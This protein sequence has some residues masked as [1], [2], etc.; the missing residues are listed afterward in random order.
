MANFI[1]DK[2][3]S[4]KVREDISDA[5]LKKLDGMKHEI[6]NRQPI[7]QKR[8]DFYEGRHDKWT[9]VT[10][11]PSKKQEGHILATFNYILKFCQKIVSVLVNQ[12]PKIKIVPKDESNEIETSRS[13]AL[14]S[15][16]RQVFKDNKFFP[17]KMEKAAVSQVRDGD[18]VI[19]CRVIKN[20]DT[21]QPEIKITPN[22]DVLK[23]SVGWD[24]A[25]GTSFSSIT[26][27]D[28][29]TLDKIKREYDF[30]AEPVGDEKTANA[31][32]RGSHNNDQ[33]GIFSNASGSDAETVPDGIAKVPKARVTDYWGWEVID[34]KAKVINIIYINK[35][36]KQFVV[37]D[38]KDIPKKVGHSFVV[39]GK[40]WSM[41]FIDPLIDPQ[42]ELNDRTGEEGDLV[43]VGSH[44]KFLVL[45]MPDFDAKSVKPGSGQVIFLE[46]ENVDFKPLQM[47]ISPF[48]SDVYLDRVMEHMFNLGLPKIALSAGTAPYT[49]RVA[50]I[51]YQPVA[52]LVESFRGKWNDVLEDLIKQIQQ[53][54]IDYFPETHSF[55][56]ESIMTEE[57]MFEDGELVIRDVTFDWD[58]ILPLSRSDKV[59]DAST[60]RD[61][62]AISL[63]TYLEQVG[64]PDPAKEIKK[65]KMEHKD[66]DLMT[67]LQKFNEFSPGAVKASIEARKAMVESEAQMAESNQI[68]QNQP[69]PAVKAPLRSQEQNDQRGIPSAMGTPTGQTASARGAVAQTS[70]NINAQSGV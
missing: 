3:V 23:V 4:S 51:Q 35:D 22:E 25:S 53:Y 46:G 63:H 17:V 57:G 5:V 31:S 62:G 40:P 9:N 41:G 16:V 61:R 67:L 14:E 8:R 54:L 45:N 26:F 56:R 64:F 32:S 42:L 38:Y 10:G 30:E 2:S 43:R 13:E 65:M 58:N 48:P 69:T 39:A 29:W 7:I 19:D 21:D 15:A 24:D 68:L 28:L 34:G 27:S 37:T 1:I 36:L 66:E 18:F 44:M 12:P 50:A 11:Q 60:L 59:V 47:S 49:G 33:Y 6:S 20:Q 70:Q 55:M 52:D